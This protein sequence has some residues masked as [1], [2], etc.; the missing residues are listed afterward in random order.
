MHHQLANNCVLRISLRSRQRR[1]AEPSSNILRRFRV[2]ANKMR[3]RARTFSI[4]RCVFSWI[5][6]FPDGFIFPYVI[7]FKIN[8][9]WHAPNHNWFWYFSILLN[10]FRSC[11]FQSKWP[12]L[13]RRC[14]KAVDKLYI[15][16]YV[17]THN[18][19]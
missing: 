13:T 9:C 12:L 17:K 19:V 3:L 8:R 18:C 1:N 2:D 6:S 5:Y 7:K 4:C 15:Y 11:Q 16:I 10:V 14:A